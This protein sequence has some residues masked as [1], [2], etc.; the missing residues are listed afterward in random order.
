VTRVKEERASQV[1]RGREGEG[2]GEGKEV[3]EGETEDMMG[4]PGLP[5]L[6]AKCELQLRI[7]RFPQPLL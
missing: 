6:R 1:V 4:W 5:A 3:I 7:F 2:E